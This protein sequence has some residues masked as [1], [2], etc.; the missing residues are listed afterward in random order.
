MDDELHVIVVFASHHFGV[1]QWHLSFQ[2]AVVR[3]DLSTQ[4]A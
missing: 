1:Q 4:V 2:S 3:D